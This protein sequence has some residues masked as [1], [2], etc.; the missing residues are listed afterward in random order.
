MLETKTDDETLLQSL[1]AL[2]SLENADVHAAAMPHQ[3]QSAVENGTVQCA[4]QLLQLAE[5]VSDQLTLLQKSVDQ[6]KGASQ[7]MRHELDLCSA[8]TQPYLASMQKLEAA[9]K[10]NKEK[11]TLIDDFLQRYQLLPDEAA[12]LE[13]GE[14]SEAFFR[15]LHRAQSIHANC[16]NLL[17]TQHQRAG[18]ELMDTMARYQEAALKRLVEWIQIKCQELVDVEAAELD[19]LMQQALQ[20]LS[21]RPVLYRYCAEEV[22]EARHDALFERFVSSLSQGPRPIEMQSDDPK[23]Y[24]NDMLAWVHQAL[25]SEI[26]L[27]ELLFKDVQRGENVSDRDLP[28]ITDL[29]NKIFQG[30]D[31]PL[32]VRIEQVLMLPPPPVL[33]FELGCLLEFYVGVIRDI[34]GEGFTLVESLQSCLDMSVRTLHEQI[35]ARGIRLVRHSIVAPRDLTPPTEVTEAIQ[36]LLQL[37]NAH[38]SALKVTEHQ[39]GLS[40]AN[41]AA[42]VLDPLLQTCKRCASEL[43]NSALHPEST[44][45]PLLSKHIFLINCL[46]TLVTLFHDRSAISRKCSE[47]STQLEVS[48]VVSIQRV[49]LFFFCF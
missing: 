24:L 12:L 27:L 31:R 35:H 15:V 26:E 40:I 9:E 29:M 11:E 2:S 18:L 42:S 16:K 20:S 36:F 32:K 6:L 45:K 4:M 41:L 28:S 44:V 23:R 3:L 25:A 33:C 46:E 43:E 7:Q 17:R 48:I 34:A 8:Q 1:T 49:P 30:I 38:E 13:S 39:E 37:L 14:V 10:M 19:P 5:G 47:L 21:T 22:A